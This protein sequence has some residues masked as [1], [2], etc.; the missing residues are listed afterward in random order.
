[1]YRTAILR[2]QRKVLKEEAKKAVQAVPLSA[3]PPVPYDAESIATTNTSGLSEFFR[4]TE[5]FGKPEHEQ[6]K[7]GQAYRQDQ[8]EAMTGAQ[9]HELW[10]VLIRQRNVFLTEQHFAW[11]KDIE[12]RCDDDPVRIIHQSL[13][14]IKKQM[15]VI[16]DR[17][18]NLRRR[19]ERRTSMRM[20]SLYDVSETGTQMEMDRRATPA[21]WHREGGSDGSFGAPAHYPLN[22]DTHG[23]ALYQSQDVEQPFYAS[24]WEGGDWD[25]MALKEDR[26]MQ[27][28]F[29][30]AKV[31]NLWDYYVDYQEESLGPDEY[32]LRTKQDFYP[33]E[34]PE[35]FRARY[36]HPNMWKYGI[37]PQHSTLGEADHLRKKGMRKVHDMSATELCNEI[38]PK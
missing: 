7:Y 27:E 6:P 23:L 28:H 9:L 8:L 37:W 11:Q 15:K 14:A 12:Y 35:W 10:C 26:R 33:S 19:E 13:E 22:P 34:A 5:F 20:T 24:T 1:M 17:V 18:N 25:K 36:S 16:D 4:E 31:Q 29:H 21:Y 3:A 32:A 38:Q 2:L 30:W